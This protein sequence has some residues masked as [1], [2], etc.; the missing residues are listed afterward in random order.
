[1]VDESKALVLRCLVGVVLDFIMNDS[2][3]LCWFFEDCPDSKCSQFD[4]DRVDKSFVPLAIEGAEQ[5]NYLSSAV[6]W[7]ELS[8]DMQRTRLM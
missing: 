8:N 6:S 1:M 3:S 4:E 5:F 7:H 2:G